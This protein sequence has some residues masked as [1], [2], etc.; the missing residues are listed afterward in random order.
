MIEY[1]TKLKNVTNGLA[2]AGSLVN[3]IDL[4][5]YH[6]TSLDQSY[7]VTSLDQSYYSI[8]IYIETKMLTIE[9]SEAYAIVF[10]HE[11]RLESSKFNDSK[12][13]KNKCA[14]NVAQAR[15]FQKKGNNNSQGN[16]NR[17][18]GSIWNPNHGGKGGFNGFGGNNKCG[19]QGQ[20]LGK[21]NQN[22]ICKGLV[23]GFNNGFIGGFNNNFGTGGFSS[24]GIENRFVQR[25]RIAY[26]IFFMIQ[27]Y[28]S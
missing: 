7:Y 18:G 20:N 25:G 19:Y 10:T 2:L 6:V 15:N 26:Q 13:V 23:D 22:N 24:R 28:C 3:N 11:A 16:W 21:R 8:V 1:F 9:P 4:I 5:T 14:A 27:S 12:E 17:G